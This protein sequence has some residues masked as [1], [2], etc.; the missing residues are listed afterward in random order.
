MERP[1]GL[2][3]A[4]TTGLGE[5]PE[6]DPRLTAGEAEMREGA[7]SMPLAGAGV[8]EVVMVGGTAEAASQGAALVATAAEEGLEA[9]VGMAGEVTG[10]AAVVM[11]G[12]EVGAGVGALPMGVEAGELVASL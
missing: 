4:S 7:A 11:E 2:A 12:A 5:A 10:A 9:V 3:W 1:R 6:R 8:T